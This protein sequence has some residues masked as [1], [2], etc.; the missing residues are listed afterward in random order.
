MANEDSQAAAV[1]TDAEHERRMAWWREARFGMFIHWGVYSLL[2]RG[3][4]VM[5]RELISDEEYA[6]VARDWKPIANATRE[7][8]R[9]ARAA[10][11]KYM[12]L[13]T[14][15]HDGVCLW[16]TAHTDWNAVKIGPERDLVREYVEAARAEGLRVGL[17]Y[18]L[19]DWN[20]PDGW[21]CVESEDARRRFVDF[22]H[23]C[24]RELMTNYGQIDI[25][26]YDVSQ[27]L[28]GP[29]A[30]ESDKLEAM[31]REL[32]PQILINDRSGLSGDFGTPEGEIKPEES[33]DWEACMTMN[34]N[35]GYVEHPDE[36][37]LSTRDIIRMLQECASAGGN[38]LLNVG[39]MPDGRFPPRAV[40][41]L[42]ALGGWAEKN[43]EAMYGR[44]DV[45]R[46]T[47]EPWGPHGFYSMR[48]NDVYYWVVRGYPEQTI[49]FAG[50]ESRLKS[51]T[52]LATGAQLPFT[53]EGR[54]I[55]VREV[56][57][58]N[59]DPAQTPVFRLRFAEPPRQKIGFHPKGI[60]H[61][62]GGDMAEVAK[63]AKDQ[64]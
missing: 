23:A 2:G 18:S 45:T 47:I 4:W 22:T 54:H 38:L 28:K 46:G 56:P 34:G 53:Q 27:P 13:G 44:M 33:R 6:E 5:N 30:W 43:G 25:L 61:T 8:A 62:L 40:D 57:A 19:M 21:R 39:P 49:R 35:W 64:M 1:A 52:L 37:W 3:E 24:V 16:D 26:W 29:A 48:G 31:V 11:M 20:H 9:L 15:H 36:D 55:T 60:P 12:V 41:R 51:V 14:K 7:W 58:A 50:F 59:L 42:R 32:Q 63:E 10:G 17:Y